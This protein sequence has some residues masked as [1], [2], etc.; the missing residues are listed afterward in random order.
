VKRG[1]SKKKKKKRKGDGIPNFPREVD[2][3]GSTIRGEPAPVKK[4]CW[5]KKMGNTKKKEGQGEGPNGQQRA[6]GGELS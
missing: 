5:N 2:R 3:G 1:H 4:F 6:G